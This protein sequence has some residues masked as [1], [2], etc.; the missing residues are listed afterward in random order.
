MKYDYVY[1]GPDVTVYLHSPLLSFASSL[2]VEG[3]K[4]GALP[5]TI[6]L[7]ERG[8]FMADFKPWLLKEY[9]SATPRAFDLLAKTLLEQS[10]IM[11]ATGPGFN[12]S[13]GRSADLVYV[14]A[15]TLNLLVDEHP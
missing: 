13:V 1:D 2:R 15:Q 3:R 9:P 10:S 6:P 4:R 12:I 11:A 8:E 5:I 7:I 14:D